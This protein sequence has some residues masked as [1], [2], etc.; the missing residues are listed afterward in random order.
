MSGATSWTEAL[1]VNLPRAL[2]LSDGWKGPQSA[3]AVSGFPVAKMPSRLAEGFDPMGYEETLGGG[4]RSLP[5]KHAFT[6]GVDAISC[7]GGSLKPWR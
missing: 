4:A 1:V 3:R 7:A 6:S 5:L 2:A